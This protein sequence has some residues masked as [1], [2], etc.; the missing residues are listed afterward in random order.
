MPDI[1]DFE[2]H[3][4]NKQMWKMGTIGSPR[5]VS[6][7][8]ARHLP[9]S[10]QFTLSSSDP[11]LDEIFHKG[12]R[13]GITY[14][15][16]DEFSGMRRP[17]SGKLTE[18]GD[19][20]FQVQGDRRILTNTLAWIAPGN[21]IA[22]TSLDGSTPE[23]RA[24]S[25]LASGA[26]VQSGT[27]QGQTGYVDW[28]SAGTLNSVEDAIKWLCK[29]N[30]IDRL[31][32]PVQIAPSQGRGGAVAG[33]LPNIRMASL[34]EGLQPLL[35]LTG[36]RIT[37]VQHPQDEFYTLDVEEQEEW[38]P[39]LTTTSGI[40]TDGDWSMSPFSASRIIVGGP[41]D[42]A[43]RAFWEVRDSTGLEEDYNDIIEVFRDAT[44]GSMN[45]PS[46]F[47]D[48]YKVAKYY[49]LRSEVA[50]GDKDEFRT[51]L[52]QA[53][54]SGLLDGQA[55]SSVSATLSETDQFHYGGDDGVRLNMSMKIKAANL[56]VFEDVVTE[57]KFSY[58]ADNGLEVQPVLG[59][60]TDDPTRKLSESILRF[61]RAQR[62]MQRSR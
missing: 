20:Q 28:S 13:V 11:M 62:K 6:G 10:F 58:T 15:G 29:V 26:V 52:E 16:V 22:P 43:A 36:L 59:S 55:L 41:G 25:N 21:P 17:L 57:A 40:V 51:Y 38:G 47:T 34:A 50:A 14:R 60:I 31:R 32:R 54:A 1:A 7:T 8:L 46:M 19:V 53:G 44:S 23:G 33:I 48:P 37:V 3:V 9:G 39:Q 18:N 56:Q 42:I 45:W 5:A 27:V 2:F 4:Y 49:L 24:Q 30:L 35:D 12:S 61:A